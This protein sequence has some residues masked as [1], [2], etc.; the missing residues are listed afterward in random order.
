MMSIAQVRSAGSAAGYYS[1]RDN[2]YV[3]GSME[4]RWAGKGAE[5]LGLQGAVDKDVFTRVLEGRL[6]DGADLSRQQDGS[7]KHRP[8]YDLTFSAPKSVSLMAMLAGDKRLTEAH[9]Q[10]VDI[11]VR[12]V[13]A[14]ASTRVMTDG[15]SET[16]LTGNLV[17]ALFNHDTSRDQEPQLHTHAVVANVTQHNGEWK[18]L[19]SDRVGKTGFIE[20]VYANQIAFGKIYRAVLKEKVEALGYETEVVGK[21]GMWEMPGVPVE[22]FSSRSQTIREAVGEDASLKSR[23]AAALD[24]RKSKQHVDPEVKMAE[25]MQT[26][27]DTGFDIS[28]YREAADRR[29]EIQAAQPAPP[30]E[31]P[32]IQQAVTQAIAGLSDRKVQF[33]YTDV[34]ARTVGMLPPEAGVIEKARAGIDE[35]ISREQLIPLDRE[36]GLFT[37]G[38]HVLDELSVRALSSDIMK[39]S[40]VTVHPEKSVPRT[41]SYSDAVSVLA[42]DRPSLAIISGQ[43]GAAGQRDRVAELMMMARE[44]GREVQIIAADR[45]SQTNL[46]QDERLSGELITGRRQ[47]QEGMT[48][49]PGSTVIVD[50]GEKLSLKETLTLLDGAA[51]HNVQVL[52]TDSGQ[53]T[54]TGSALMAMKEAGVNSYR[55]QGG[56]QTP[57]TVISEP[58]RNVR[59]ARLAGDFVAAVKAG[60]ESVAQVSGVRE[61]AILAGMIRSELKTQGILGQQDTMMT[62]LSPVWLD[63][64]SRYLRDMYREGMVMEQWNPEKHSHDRYVIDR[65]TAQSHSLTLRDAQ[66]ETQMVRI[67]ALDS[68]WSLF[69]PEK[70]PVADGERLMVT[71]KIPGL[72]VSGGDRLQVSAVNDGVMTVIVPGR[73]EPASLPVGDSPFTALKLE[74]GWVETPGHS[75]SDSAKVFASVTQMAMDNAT[76]NGLARS[77]RDVRLYSSLDETRTAEKLSRHPSFT[78]VSEQIKARAGEAS[79]ESAISLQ[80]AGLHTPAQQAIHLAIPVVESKNLAFSQADLLAEAKSFAAEGTGFADLGREI[81]AQIKRGDLL[82]VDVAKGYGTD[83]LVSRASYDAEKSI[84]HHILEGKEAVTPL[85]ERVPGE[86]M[87]TLTS[88][89]RAAT[90]MILETKDRFTVVQGY[91]GVGKTTQFRAVM[92][93]VNLLPEDERPRVIGLGPT[94]RAVGEMRSAGVEAQ[95]LASFL[96]D[97]QMQQRSGAAPD[98]SNTLF[99]LDESSMVGNTDMARAYALIAAGGGRA[100]AS[101]DTDQLQAIAPGQPFRLQQTRSAADVAI[102]KEIVRQTPELRDAVYSLINRDVNEALSGLE[103]VKPAQVPRLEG[104]WAPENSVTEFSRLQERELA[105]AAQEAEKKGE[106]FPDVPMTLYEAIVRDYTGRTPEAREQTLIVTHLNADRRTLNSMIHDVREK[107]GELGEQQADIPV[108]TTANIRDGELRRLSAWE[109]HPGALALVDRVYHRIAGISKDDGLIT[110]EDKAGNIR[111]ISP[112]EA[113]AEGVTLYKPETIRVGTGDRMRFTKSDPER[114]YVANSVWTVTAVSGDSVTLSDGQQTRVIHPG[115]EQAEQHIDLAYAITAHGAQGASETFAIALEG[116]EGGRKQMAGFESAYVALSRMKQH[117]QVYTDDRQ[118]WVKAIN[119]AEQKG[120]AH[121]VLEPKSEREI[122]NAERLFSTA[123]ELRD[124]AAGRAVL[125]NAG[126]AQGDSRAR[127]IAPGRKYPQPYV[128]L[129]AF[130]RNG[131]SAGIWLNPLTTDDGAGLRGFSGEG[132]VKGSEEAQFVALQGSRNGESLLAAD[133]QEGVRF[134]RENPDSG[135]VVRIAGDGRPWNPGAITGGRVWGDIP[136]SSVQPGAGNGEPVTAEILAQQQAEEAVRR[137]TEQRAAEI[138][139]KMAEDK[140]DLPEEKTAQ[141]VREV[142][143]QE[144]DRMTPPE[145]ETPLPESVLREPVRERETIREVARENRVRERLQQMEQE[146]VRDLQKEKTPGGD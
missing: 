42:Q 70:I 25:W 136:D 142:A 24:T 90:R 73:A 8:G 137:E 104:V 56:Q 41:G 59:Y 122:L 32:D 141:T 68:S 138:V 111:L 98:F 114:G 105:K 57:A 99:L 39:Q 28:A 54:G 10:A 92:S 66:G 7:N 67:S 118:G 124:V 61:Q 145:R 134:A 112:R 101:G 45:R 80:K 27:K 72:R 121:D 58:D 9:N 53:R 31:Q 18:T 15:Q 13:E 16:V 48:F 1:D 106:A 130:D 60:E 110:L 129:P 5:Q 82:H 95:T 96:H 19:S 76:L 40:R 128:A 33:T 143:G 6:P 4:E 47:L 34:L 94:H 11:A 29:A 62:A 133:M 88:G 107:A 38:I 131:K 126:L 36:K 46:K 12:Q 97:T 116:T 81:D 84:L 69:R 144:Q 17:M 103:N 74:N 14:L 85:M 79:L 120:T 65:V 64:R 91:A 117:V 75:V 89:Q 78:V 20:N 108:L 49:S 2:Y 86:L 146:M 102:M 26:L 140:T 132:R 23:D 22:A 77:G 113:S 83:L 109:A 43:G 50:Q 30:Q 139:R 93:A 37:S 87:E 52:I 55:W 63:S 119:S 71:G 125:R 127:F 135:V 3:L 123:R 35:A 21:H 115:Q 51:R 44:Q 100:V